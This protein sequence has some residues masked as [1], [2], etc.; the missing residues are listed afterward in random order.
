MTSRGYAL[1]LPA[2]SGAARRRRPDAAQWTARG[3]RLIRKKPS[4]RPCAGGFMY[5]A[6]R[7]RTACVTQEATGEQVP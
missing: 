4:T 5:R 2:A 3:F 1:P 6:T 7:A